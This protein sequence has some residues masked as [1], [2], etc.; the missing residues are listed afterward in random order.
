[1]CLIDISLGGGGVAKLCLID[2]SLG[3]GGVAKLCLIDSSLGGGGGGQV[4]PDRYLIRG[5]VPWSAG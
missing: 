2:S 3:G 4:V 1:M 5:S